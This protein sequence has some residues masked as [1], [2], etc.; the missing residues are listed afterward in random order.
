MDPKTDLD[1]VWS[2][3]MEENRRDRW[4]TSQRMD[5][6]SLILLVWWLLQV[7]SMYT[8]I[9]AGG[10]THKEDIHTGALAAAAGGFASG[11]DG[12]Y[13]SDHFRYWP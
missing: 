10:Q 9:S 13:Q 1:Q 6:K 2:S 5:K 3:M 7:W 12:Q 4:E 8:S 11:H